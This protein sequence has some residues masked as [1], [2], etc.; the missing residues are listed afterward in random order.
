MKTPGKIQTVAILGGGPAAAT[1]AVRLVKKNFRVAIFHTPKRAPLIVGESL[2]PAII[3]ILQ[4]LG[5]EDEV[6]GYSQFKP[7]ATFNI[8]AG[9]NYSFFFEQLIGTA[10]YS[11]NVPREKFDETI[12]NCARRA[13]SFRW[14]LASPNLRS[15]SR[16]SCLQLPVLGT[17]RSRIS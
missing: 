13:P 3:P 17:T 4:E 11:Y 1:L 16:Y 8:R 7:G 15:H 2:V 14:A 12:L 5:V 9:V 10:R 6:K